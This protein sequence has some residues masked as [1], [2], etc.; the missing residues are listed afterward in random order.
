MEKKVSSEKIE[1]YLEQIR[2]LFREFSTEEFGDSWADTFEIVEISGNK[3]EIVYFGGQSL[4][5]FKKECGDLLLSCVNSILGEEKKLK[6]SKKVKGK[7][8]RVSR[9]PKSSVR[10]KRVISPTLARR[11]KAVK[12]FVTGIVCVCFA[13]A[14]L[15][16]L[17]NYVENRSFRETFYTA[18]SIKIDSPI[19]VIQ[20]SD[21]HASVYGDE[22]EALLERIEALKPDIILCTG[23]IVNSAETEAE[24]AIELSEKLSKIAPA[25]YIYGNNEKETIYDFALNEQALDE[26]FGFEAGTRDENA[27]LQL[28]DAF[29]EKLENAGVKVLKNEMDT[30]TVKGMQVDVYGVLTSNPSC[31]WSYSE[32]A[33]LGYLYENPDHVKITAVHEPQIFEDFNPDSSWGDLAVCGHTHGGI[34]RVPLLGPLYTHE[35]GLFP[36]R[37]GCY[38]YGRYDDAG[39]PLI[40]S[41]GLENGNVLRINNRPELVVIDINKF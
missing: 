34:V 30:I 7:T 10:E 5:V 17:A 31:F 41:G 37:S 3:V 8:A 23:D 6:I 29:E 9:E 12:L 22:N 16:V 1:Q 38:V 14:V 13:A 33:F 39:T 40:V 32:N 35:G 15:Y 21:L 26:K 27:L 36:D 18:S 11:I 28:P 19:R 20:L 25:Y 24:Y 2:S 4:A